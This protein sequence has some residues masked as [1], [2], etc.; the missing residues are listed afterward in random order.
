MS[1]HFTEATSTPTVANIDVVIPSPFYKGGK[2]G[3][4]KLSNFFKVTQ[5]A[6]GGS[7]V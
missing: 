3:P 5:L 1:W 2:G 6:D 7:Q 4:E